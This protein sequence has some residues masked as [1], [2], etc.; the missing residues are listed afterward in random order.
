MFVLYI[1]FRLLTEYHSFLLKCNN[2][3]YRRLKVSV[4]LR[5]I[6][7]SYRYNYLLFTQSFVCFRLLTEYHSFLFWGHMHEAT[8]MKVFGFRLLTE[9]HSFLFM[10]RF[11]KYQ[12]NIRKWVSVSL[13]SIIHSYTV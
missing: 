9:Y 10:K 5:S 8:I 7:H 1:S 13:R 12:F 3:L 2:L 4:S 11:S 6:I